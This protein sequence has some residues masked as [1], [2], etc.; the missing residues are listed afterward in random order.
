MFEAKLIYKAVESYLPTAYP[1]YY[2]GAPDN[3]VYVV[4][5]APYT[6]PAGKSGIEFIIAK[7]EEFTFNYL[8]ERLVEIATQKT[9]LLN[10]LVDKRNLIVTTIKS[11]KSCKNYDDAEALLNKWISEDKAKNAKLSRTKPQTRNDKV[12]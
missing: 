3:K 7:N 10:S 9:P 4:Y 12:E 2:Y 6:T 11:S 5:S 8:E 1:A